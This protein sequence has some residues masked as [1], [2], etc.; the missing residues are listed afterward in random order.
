[1]A[2]SE[3][4]KTDSIPIVDA[5]IVGLSTALELNNEATRTT[6]EK[7]GDHSNKITGASSLKSRFDNFS[8][9]TNGLAAYF[10]PR[11]GWVDAL[12]AVRFLAQECSRRGISFITGARERA[13]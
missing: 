4:L 1:M 6:S 9:A 10:N 5:G 13:T 8:A 11:G 12:S 3:P 2:N 7:L